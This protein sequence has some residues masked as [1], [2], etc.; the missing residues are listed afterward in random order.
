MADNQP[1]MAPDDAGPLGSPSPP[2]PPP[3]TAPSGDQP[4]GEGQPPPPPPPPPSPQSSAGAAPAPTPALQFF[5]PPL[6]T[7]PPR[8]TPP[9]PSGGHP[10]P[11]APP[12]GLPDLGAPAPFEAPTAAPSATDFTKPSGKR[13][14]GLIAV[15]AGLIVLIAG[16]S[17]AGFLLTR[18]AAGRTGTTTSGGSGGG[19]GTHTAVGTPA[20]S[21]GTVS[22]TDPDQYYTAQFASEP[23]YHSTSQTSPV[24]NVPYRY[25][26]YVGP[27]V[28]QLVGVLVFSPGTSFDPAKGLQGIASAGNGSVVSSTPSTFQGYPSLE[29]VINLQGDYLKV[30]IVHVGNLAYI[31]GTA[32]PVNPPSDYARF[33]AAV[34]ITPH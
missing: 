12:L 28:D 20:T 1:P 10:A 9:P 16:G 4:E 6:P 33:I 19:V 5:G 18:P 34:H 22:Y 24:G 8:P 27:D 21:A 23:T 2:P 30:Q 17:A 3:G 13:R 25:A 14:T 32:G 31:I 26:E 7:T 15:I 11:T 29:G